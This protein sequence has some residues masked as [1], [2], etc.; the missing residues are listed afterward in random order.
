MK[1]LYR[2]SLVALSVLALAS[3][4]R[5]AAA[6]SVV[7]QPYLQKLTPS[8][9]FIVWTTDIV[10]DSRVLYGTTPSSLTQAAALGAATTQHE[11]LIEGL[12]PDTRYYYS[13]G[14]STG[15]LA[16]GDPTFYF[17]T[18]PLAGARKK[19]RAWIVG[20]SGYNHLA[21]RQVRDAMLAVVGA[22]RPQIFLHLG[23][24]AYNSGTTDEF[25]TNFFGNYPTILRN[26]VVWPALGNHEGVSSD[27]GAQVGPYYTAY[28]LP[29]AG[30][31]GG[32][33]SGTEAYYSFDHAN[34]HFIVLDSYDSPRRPGGAMLSWLQAD[35]AATS[36][37]WIV[38]FWH[39]PPYT[40][41][42]HDSDLDGTEIEIRQNVVPI[43]EAGGVDLVL[44]GHS[45]IYERS[46]LV[47]GAYD[48]PTTAAGH[49]VDAGDGKPLGDGPYVKLAGNPGHDGAV[50]VVAGHGAYAGG[51]GDHPLMYF[52]EQQSGSCILDV[53][54][55]RLSVSNI[56]SDG[57]VSDRFS[58]IK[59]PGLVVAA[60][61]GGERLPR[62]GSTTI[63]WATSGSIPTV[64]I[65][66]SLDSGASWAT[67]ADGLANTGRYA[68]AVPSLDSTQA[69]IRVSDAANASVFDESNAGFSIQETPQLAVFF[70]D[71]W[72]FDDRGVDLGTAWR[73]LAYDDSG[74]RAGPGQLGFG[75]GD[76]ATVLAHTTPSYPSAYFRK[77]IPIS[78][79]VAQATLK[80][81][82][83]DGVIV[84][85]NGSQV[86][87]RYT[88]SPGHA[89]YAS[90]GSLDNETTTVTLTGAPFVVGSNVIA[91]MVKQSDPGSTDLSFDME[92]AL[93]MAPPSPGGGGS[94]SSS[95]SA[96][97]SSGVAS[98]S[99]SSSGSV[100]SSTHASTVGAGGGG[101]GGTPACVT[102]QRGTNGWAQ[103][104]TIWQSSPTWNDGLSEA[105]YTGDATGGYRSTLLEFDLSFIPAGAEVYAATLTLSQ[106]Y[107]LTSSTVRVHEALSP[108][109]E[110]TVTWGNYLSSWD[111]LAV[112]SFTS[113]GGAGDRS[114]DITTL[115]QGWVGGRPNHGLLLEEDPG[116]NTHFRSS[117]Y[118]TASRR[119]R[120][121]V[122]YAPPPPSTGSLGDRVWDDRDGD[123]VQDPGEEGL[124]GVTV[125]L[126]AD[127]S[128]SGSYAA[129]GSAVTEAD[130]GY[131]FSELPSGCYRVAV[132]G[133]T[134]PVG[135]ALSSSSAS[136]QVVLAAGEDALDLDF[137]YR[138]PRPALALSTTV[139][140]D[141]SCPGQEVVNVLAGTGL[142]FCYGVTN[143]GDVTVGNIVVRDEQVGDL[144]GGGVTLAPG[145]GATFRRAAAATADVTVRATAFGL[146][147]VMDSLVQA[148]FD[149]AIVHVLNPGIRLDVTVSDTGACPGRDSLE[150][151]HGA[152]VLPCYTLTNVGRDALVDVDV[153]DDRGAVLGSL[154]NLAPGGS[155]TL[156]GPAVAA[157]DDL[158][159]RGDASGTDPFGFTV[160]DS[161]IALVEVLL[162]DLA[163]EVSAP[164]SVTTTTCAEVPYEITVTNVGPVRSAP[165]ITD[166]LPAGLALVSAR[167]PSGTCAGAAGTVTC[168]LAE[169]D[170]G[171]SATVTV[172]TVPRIPDGSLTNTVAMTGSVRDALSANDVAG[173]VTQL[174]PPPLAP[175]EQIATRFNST[176]ISAGGTLWFTGV[177]RLSGLP[178]TGATIVRAT[179]GHITFSAGGRSH[180]IAVPG[181]EVRLDPDLVSATTSYDAE[182]NRWVTRAPASFTGDVLLS[183]AAFPVPVDLPGGVGPVTWSQHVAADRAGVSVSR[184]WGA[185]VYSTF[186]SD[187]DALGVRASGA[188]RYADRSD[189]AGVPAAFTAFLTAGGTGTGKGNYVGTSTSAATGSP[190]VEVCR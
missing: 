102:L 12:A 8:S 6:Q 90:Q 168:V 107:K 125:A 169:L 16:G 172:I 29:T 96:S 167:S 1:S 153:R 170:P 21:P 171:E 149:P 28:V 66:V 49:I 55:N 84:W 5:P 52:S 151:S 124:A 111:A 117:E 155:V 19:F 86:L 42:S 57:V 119:P 127:P 110:S 3:G 133:T 13:V 161:D 158:S 56:R 190:V 123:A 159:I 108:W 134:V 80:V 83:D 186:S 175:W 74:W 132:D 150:V 85:V 82:H 174:L 75:D 89:D 34:V 115:V 103:D 116:Q 118:V 26:T 32:L 71:T 138:P 152:S 104:A 101:P 189:Y 181:A 106:V 129:A 58:M 2:K 87:S 114:V 35:L 81:Q 121:E 147:V 120:L 173:A 188:G 166:A 9:V 141:G 67:I 140:L 154:A 24:M 182:R 139:S 50:Y 27:S 183:A 100:S 94:S 122:C 59:G 135:Y 45:H 99:A 130:G 109:N 176:A 53:Q 51:P 160:S 88:T 22:Y 43:L 93:T 92:L 39:H 157:G 131:L 41:G 18:A 44:S 128:C 72:T 187:Y 20:D 145:A 14:S 126:L 30:E 144:P 164:D 69:L 77:V 36:Q 143:T 31:A 23:D 4:A 165:T 17:E 76:E 105:L 33:P 78:G 148:D 95:S 136:R 7:R 64:R 15:V 70:G 91:A 68:W 142:T 185:A 112:A 177:M 184:R 61:D 179:G 73:A 162:A 37:D 156:P 25:T 180:D 98:S 79:A 146:D 11:V 46:Y 54:D 163:L 10:T 40:K 47:D 38:G 137:G 113:G 62:G 65:E 97:S 63:R 48:T 60:P 178:A